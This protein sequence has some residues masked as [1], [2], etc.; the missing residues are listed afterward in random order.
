MTRFLA[1]VF[2]LAATTLA[3]AL[4]GQ[5]APMG[6][7]VSDVPSP[8]SPLHGAAPLAASI[9]RIGTHRD[10]TLS[11][12]RLRD[13]ETTESL[14]RG[15]AVI[16]LEAGPSVATNMALT[17]AL[18]AASGGLESRHI[19]GYR[20]ST[21]TASE[22]RSGRW[23]GQFFASEAAMADPALRSFASSRGI[24]FSSLSSTTLSAPTRLLIVIDDD[25]VTID[26]TKKSTCDAPIAAPQTSP[27]GLD[28]FRG[29]TVVQT[30]FDSFNRREIFAPGS[31]RRVHDV[32]MEQMAAE[33]ISDV[34][35]CAPENIAVDAVVSGD[36][37]TGTVS[38]VIVDTNACTRILLDGGEG[39]GRTWVVRTRPGSS[40]AHVAVAVQSTAMAINV[41]GVP[42]D[43]VSRVQRTCSGR[44]STPL[45]VL[46]AT[47]VTQ[48]P[49]K[50]S[51]TILRFSNAARQ[52]NNAPSI[53]PQNGF[54]LSGDTSIVS[55][56]A[57]IPPYW[58]VRFAQ[59][60]FVHTITRLS[61]EPAVEFWR[62]GVI[63]PDLCD[64]VSGRCSKDPRS[65]DASIV[66]PEGVIAYIN[67]QGQKQYIPIPGG[68]ASS[69][70]VSS[71]A[72][73]ADHEDIAFFL[74]TEGGTALARLNRR[75]G[76]LAT[77]PA[78]EQQPILAWNG[79]LLVAT[80]G[81]SMTEY[82]PMTLTERRRVSWPTPISL[83]LGTPAIGSAVWATQTMSPGALLRSAGNQVLTLLVGDNHVYHAPQP[84][85]FMTIDAST[86]LPVG[87]VQL[88]ETTPGNV[89]LAG[90]DAARNIVLITTQNGID[91]PITHLVNIAD[92]QAP[93]LIGT[94]RDASYFPE[95]GALS[96]PRYGTSPRRYDIVD[97]QSGERRES[98]SV[99]GLTE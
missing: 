68:F 42:A 3:L 77:G 94:G 25:G 74:Q 57:A 47:R 19:Y 91:P 18:K 90:I 99:C 40:V 79:E 29:G 76:E 34:T 85:R 41:K 27:I 65:S 72:V 86:L 32:V 24:T 10:A 78:V 98:L 52:R 50:A 8:F 97:V 4:H 75:T 36:G 1:I 35:P 73:H 81:I 26:V 60:W 15:T 7:A 23:I 84:L 31:A 87:S 2:V 33:P 61:E 88:L 44:C 55:M 51:A 89:T 59:S 9:A 56:P 63:F 80:D 62:G 5:S 17:S 38:E 6:D 64:Q 54:I 66:H 37:M 16:F 28:Q 14:P 53:E 69:V 39:A 11:L 43:Q 48:L 92:P 49:P 71:I 96:S 30:P 93:L 13:G 12:V 20:Y 70:I 58:I 95:Q 45:E 22:E 21:P 46:N 82:D 67:L 83:P